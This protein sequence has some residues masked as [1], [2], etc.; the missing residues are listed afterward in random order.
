MGGLRVMKCLMGMVEALNMTN[1]L[2]I[3]NIK[4][5]TGRVSGI[6]KKLSILSL[7]CFMGP[8][9]VVVNVCLLPSSLREDRPLLPSLLDKIRTHVDEL[10]DFESNEEAYN[11]SN[12]ASP[13]NVPVLDKKPVL[14]LAS[15]A[16][17]SVAKESNHFSAKPDG[18]HFQSLVPTELDVDVPVENKPM[19]KS[20]RLM[21]RKSKNRKVSKKPKDVT[22]KELMKLEK[23]KHRLHSQF[24]REPTLAEW[25]KALG[26]SCRDLRSY[27]CSGNSSREK[28]IIA[29]FRLVFHVAKRYQGRGLSLQDLFQI[30]VMEENG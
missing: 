3:L 10:L 4:C 27:L 8:F 9:M 19:V 29:N 20:R 2:K 30:E 23:V 24:D 22:T 28:M 7:S 6:C 11:R 21:Q 16:A 18:S 17:T 26:M 12:L 5:F 13:G 25:A 14:A 1:A 15:Q